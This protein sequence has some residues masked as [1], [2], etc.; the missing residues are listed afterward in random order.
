[1]VLAFFIDEGHS[2]SV[3][4]GIRSDVTLWHATH[5]LP[6]PFELTSVQLLWDR[7]KRLTGKPVKHYQPFPYQK[8][9]YMVKVLLQRGTPVTTVL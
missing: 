3:L 7:A 5:H 8:W 9:L 1:M 6:S 2:S 4:A